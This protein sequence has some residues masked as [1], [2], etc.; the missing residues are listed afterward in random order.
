MVAVSGL[1]TEGEEMVRGESLFS[2]CKE[3]HCTVAFIN[4]YMTIAS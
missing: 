2:G 3:S 4:L 1:C